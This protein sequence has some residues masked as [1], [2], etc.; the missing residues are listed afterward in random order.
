[1]EST[2]DLI[3]MLIV[4]AVIDKLNAISPYLAFAVL[5]VTLVYGILK[6]YYFIKNKGK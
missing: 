2:L 4:L 3:L 5:V 6:I 1:M